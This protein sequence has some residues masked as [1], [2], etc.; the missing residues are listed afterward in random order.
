MIHRFF[1]N[2]WLLGIQKTFTVD[3]MFVIPRLICSVPY[4]GPQLKKM[5]PETTAEN[6]V[7]SK[8]RVQGEGER[9][10]TWR[11]RG[12]QGDLVKVWVLHSMA[13][14]K[15]LRLQYEYFRGI[16]AVAA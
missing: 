2:F 1:V 6:C 10:E 12:G 15:D 4:G 14:R 16:L 3:K 7:L 13:V 11:D 5:D 9:N 8:Y